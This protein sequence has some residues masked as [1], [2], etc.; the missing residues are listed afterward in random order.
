MLLL[1]SKLHSHKSP[2]LVSDDLCVSQCSKYHHNIRTNYTV[3]T[4]TRALLTINKP[5]KIGVVTRICL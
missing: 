4:A 2:S 1:L 5:R 3:V